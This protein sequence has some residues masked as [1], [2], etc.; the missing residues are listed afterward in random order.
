SRT[1]GFLNGKNCSHT[2]G[3]GVIYLKTEFYIESNETI[4]EVS[5]YDLTAPTPGQHPDY[6]ALAADVLIPATHTSPAKYVSLYKVYNSAGTGN[7]TNGI[8]WVDMTTSGSPKVLTED[9]VFEVGHI[10]QVNIAVATIGNNV[11]ATNSNTSPNV[12]AKVNGNTATASKWGEVGK[13]LQLSYRFPAAENQTVSKVAITGLNAPQHGKKADYTAEVAAESYTL[14]DTNNVFV[15]N[16][17]SWYDE[18]GGYDMTANDTFIGGHTYVATVYLTPANGYQFAASVTGTINGKSAEVNAKSTLIEVKYTYTLAVNKITK[19]AL[20][21]LSAPATGAFPSYIAINKG[22]GYKLKNRNDNY[23]RNGICWSYMDGSDL[24]TFGYT[25]EGGKQYQV[26]IYLTAEAGYE[27]DVSSGGALNVKAT[28][29]GNNVP[30][31]LGNKDEIVLI[32]YFPAATATTGIT[33]I[34]ISDVVAPVIGAKPTYTAS[35]YDIGRTA[36]KTDDDDRF[37]K[38]GVTWYN[39][40]TGNAITVGSSTT[41]EAD[42]PYSVVVSVTAKD[43]YSFGANVPGTINGKEAKLIASDTYNLYYQYDF[44]ALKAEIVTPPANTEVQTPVQV[45]TTFS[46]VPENAYFHDP[47]QWAVANQITNGTSTTTFSPNTT[48]S[49]A[50]ILTF[51]WRAVGSPASEMANPYSNAVVTSNQYFYTPFIWSWEK[52]LIGNTAHDPNA[53]CSRSDVVTY[54]WKLAGKPKAAKASFADV[55]ADA[56]YAQAVAWA[57]EQG[58]TNGTSATTFSPNDTCTRGQ[59]VTFLWRYME[60][61]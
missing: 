13:S 48:C 60:S 7:F 27:F 55:A 6:T 22:D 36:I 61:K 23:Y 19:V 43:G 25:F 42:I 57:V 17:I 21:D 58:I 54:L 53:P 12:T 33:S 8:T 4:R 40:K 10:Y 29:N 18:T 3:T 2:G 41:F 15:K 56:P 5:I 45:E 16:G 20:E 59:I 1:V 11:F 38:N 14:K 49:Q 26:T 28:L 24:P 31:I 50:H 39:E 52:G 32:Y 35:V 44:P 46:D 30:D 37:T 51:L 47:V 34:T 9:S